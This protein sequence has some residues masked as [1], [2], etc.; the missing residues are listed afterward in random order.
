MK[1][2]SCHWKHAGRYTPWVSVNG[3]SHSLVITIIRSVTKPTRSVLKNYMKSEEHISF[4]WLVLV[5]G[6]FKNV[7]PWTIY[8]TDGWMHWPL[9]CKQS[10]VYSSMVAAYNQQKKDRKISLK[11]KSIFTTNVNTRINKRSLA[12]G[13]GL[14]F[15]RNPLA[16]ENTHNG[17]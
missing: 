16:C 13:E 11:V 8:S 14:N 2:R 12:A 1:H 9:D 10:I 17:W 3:N 6:H 5:N 7:L 15:E 4:T